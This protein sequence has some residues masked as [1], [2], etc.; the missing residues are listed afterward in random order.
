MGSDSVGGHYFASGETDPWLTIEY[1][2]DASG[3][4]EVSLT[5]PGFSLNGEMPVLGRALVVHASQGARVG[6][7]LIVPQLGKVARIGTYPDY[8]GATT[9]K[10]LLSFAESSSGGLAIEGTLTGLEQSVSGGYHVHAGYSC[11]KKEGVFGHY[12]TGGSDP[13][14]SVKYSS[15][16]TGVA[17]LSH[18]EAGFS[19]TTMDAQAVFGRT[20]VVHETGGARAGSF[21]PSPPTAAP[22]IDAL[23]ARSAGPAD[24]PS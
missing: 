16:P 4:A 18:V 21:G 2:S 6:C 15:D 1:T 9:I 11:D 22:V 24:A 10:G 14:L 17:Q 5:I 20:F 3:V 7:G 12:Y 8:S 23:L 13:W 19:L